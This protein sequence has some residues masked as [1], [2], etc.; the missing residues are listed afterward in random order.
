MAIP[1]KEQ[2][3]LFAKSGNRCA[4]EGCHRILTAGASPP[5]GPVV[6]GEAA[7][8]VAERP[9]GPR[10]NYPF[11]LDKRNQYNNLILLCNQHHQ[12]VDSQQQ[13]YT[14]EK[15]RAMKE[16]HEK[17]V[18]QT[19]GLAD[20]KLVLTT[21][22]V[23]DVVYSTL[24][25]VERLPAYIYGVPCDIT[26]EKAVQARIRPVRD[27]EIAP[28]IIRE[29]ML[30]AFQN[31]NALGNPFEEFVPGRSA[32]RFQCQE[33]WED[34]D[35]MRWFVQLLNRTLNK[36][37]GRRGL[38]LDKE[39]RRYYFEPREPNQELTISYR[40]L[41]QNRSSRNVVWQRRRRLTHEP[42]GYWYHR[43][44]SLRFVRVDTNEWC[45]S[46]RPELRIT[47]DGFSAP[48]P[49]RIGP[50][51]TKQKSHRFNYDLLVEVNFWRDYL[52][53]GKPRII[54][55]FGPQ[56]L[57]IIPTTL[58]SG[59]VSWPG[60]PEEYAKPFK[61]VRYIDDLFSWGELSQLESAIDEDLEEEL[62][63]EDTG[64]LAKEEEGD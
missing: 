1:L 42:R 17:W 61:N 10:G 26:H 6:L 43:A 29:G 11:P 32:E 56:Q 54:L 34:P 16:A 37:T 53:D 58:I 64:E 41:N 63:P 55:S 46:I 45:L 28:F 2:R 13:T 14:V 4:F 57:L 50:R 44:V 15:L 59:I 48:P 23:E 36:L 52:S 3:I 38:K 12:L 33:W 40:P 21:P 18:E 27:Y 24:L 9:D 8:I 39:H 47:V 31:M 19:L 5:E 25:H 30:Y 7:H 35:R 49:S 60:I 20:E 62:S 22:N 51:V